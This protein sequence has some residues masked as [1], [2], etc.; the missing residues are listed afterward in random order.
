[1]VKGK[2]VTVQ[3]EI[4]PS[5]LGFT[6]PHEHIFIDLTCL[7]EEP[8]TVSERAL[9]NAP[10]S[11][12]NYWWVFRNPQCCKD[13]LILSD[14]HEALE[15]VLVFKR[16]GGGTIVDATN[17]G[18]GRDPTAVRAISIETGV[19]VIAGSGYY[20]H[21]AC[22]GNRTIEELREEIVSDLSEGIGGTGIRAG[23]IGE[24]GISDPML[25]D[26]EK[27]LR[28]SARA[29]SET[30][31]PIEVHI[32]MFSK[33]GAR[34]LDILDGEGIDPGSVV[35]CHLDGTIDD[36]EYHKSLAEKGAFLEYDQFGLGCY[37]DRLKRD[38]PQDGEL[39]HAVREM[40]EEG[41]M[42]RML[43]SHDICTKGQLTSYGGKGY[44][45]LP[46]SVVPQMKRAGFTSAEVHSLMVENP[47]RMLTWS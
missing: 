8:S 47:M 33:L 31:A 7:L 32:Q 40:I 34:V 5:E 9:M 20:H 25:P 15:E 26:E 4:S 27:V 39:L 24:I 43:L 10:V 29:S 14:Y 13:N 11:Q 19:N 22:M 1:M 12:E 28:A 2:V 37:Y 6:L 30:G 21:P 3:G 41:F 38:V 46:R 42:D 18:I 16:A 45:H 36:I 17:I 35:I 23:M 44:A